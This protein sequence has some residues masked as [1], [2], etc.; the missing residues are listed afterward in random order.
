ML[1]HHTV[2]GKRFTITTFISHQPLLA[3]HKVQAY[4]TTAYLLPVT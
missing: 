4:Y 1:L 2:N 3:L